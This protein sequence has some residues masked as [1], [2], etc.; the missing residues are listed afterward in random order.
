MGEINNLPLIAQIMLY[1][2]IMFWSIFLGTAVSISIIAM[3][4]R[5]KRWII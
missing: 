3:I 5:V 2:G 4:E 1:T